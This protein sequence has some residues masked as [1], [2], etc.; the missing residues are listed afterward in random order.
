M[1]KELGTNYKS[2]AVK[3]LN[4]KNVKIAGKPTLVIKSREF[5][6]VSFSKL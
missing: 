5:E 6:T 2:L 4:K 3:F 1:V